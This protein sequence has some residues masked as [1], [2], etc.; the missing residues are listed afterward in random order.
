MFMGAE[1][2]V[3]KRLYSAFKWFQ[4]TEVLFD[5]RWATRRRRTKND[6]DGNS[7]TVPGNRIIRCAIYGVVVACEVREV[8]VYRC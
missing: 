7:V 2:M 3:D 4:P 6:P 5:Q 1:S 8:E